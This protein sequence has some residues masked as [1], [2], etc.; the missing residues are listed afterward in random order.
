MVIY[1]HIPRTKIY[2]F[3]VAMIALTDITCDHPA[4]WFGPI[5]IIFWEITPFLP[6][7]FCYIMAITTQHIEDGNTANVSCFL[8]CVI[9]PQSIYIFASWNILLLHFWVF[10]CGLPT[11]CR[12]TFICLTMNQRN[13][14]WVLFLLGQQTTQQPT[15]IN[16][17]DGNGGIIN[18]KTKCQ[19]SIW[20][21]QV[22]F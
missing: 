2:Q 11:V 18:T 1:G 17:H 4:T 20:L 7:D 13:N 21:S 16:Y 22:L 8:L 14:K 6:C 19:Q 10:L 9:P 3:Q 5:R 12:G 15:W